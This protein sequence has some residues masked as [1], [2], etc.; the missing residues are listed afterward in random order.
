MRLMRNNQL[1]NN[2]GAKHNEPPE[3][4]RFEKQKSRMKM[5]FY[6]CGRNMKNLLNIK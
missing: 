4:R 3:G 2:Q 5:R 6:T 1:S